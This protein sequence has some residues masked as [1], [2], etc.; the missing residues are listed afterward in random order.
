MRGC[1]YSSI[2]IGLI[3]AAGV[4]TPAPAA[5]SGTLVPL[6]GAASTLSSTEWVSVATDE[7][8]AGGTRLVFDLEGFRIVPVEI[9]GRR[10]VDVRIDGE[11]QLRER[12]APALPYVCR[13]IIIPDDARMDVRV[14]ASS[15]RE[16]SD[17][18][19]IPSKGP[20]LRTVDP[21]TIPYEFGAVYGEDRWYPEDL[22]ARREPY[23]LRDYRGL[24]VELHP[25]QYNPGQRRLRV[26]D[27][28]EVEVVPVGAAEHNLLTRS[29]TPEK[30]APV[31]AGLYAEHFLNFVPP[32]SN[33]QLAPGKMLIIAHDE[34]V[35]YMEPFVTWKNQ[36]GLPT[37]LV[38]LSHTGAGATDPDL[39]LAYIQSLYRIHNLA[40]VLLVG[41][42]AQVPSPYVPFG[43]SDPSYSLVEG[44]DY[45]PDL[46]VGRLSAETVEGVIL[47]V[48]KFVDYEQSPEVG[49]SWYHKGVGIGSGQG[50]E[51]GDDD[52]ADFIHIDYIR[53]D[54]LN[55]TYTQVDTIYAA[56]PYQATAQMVTDAV[57]AGRSIINYCGHGSSMRWT[58]TGFSNE[59]V[60]ALENHNQLPWVFS[61]ACKNG[62][63]ASGTC[64][65]EAWL[66]ASHNGMPTGAV[67]MYASSAD[68]AWAPPMAAQDETVDLLVAESE[69]VFGALC[70]RGSLLMMDE[71]DPGGRSEF[72]HWHIFGDPSMVV[73]C[74]TP[75]PLAVDHARRIDPEAESFTLSVPGVA[76]A[77]CALS[78]QGTTL[79]SALTDESGDARIEGLAPLPRHEAI[80]LTVTG[81]NHI[82]HVA[83][84][85]VEEK[86][87][88][89]VDLN[90]AGLSW[91]LEVGGSRTGELRI[92][93]AAQGVEPLSFR[94]RL[95]NIDSGESVS[96]LRA[97]PTAGTI[98]AGAVALIELDASAADL[99]AGSHEAEIVV[100]VG[101]S[102]SAA[103]LVALEVVG[104]QAAVDNGPGARGVPR[105]LTLQC[106]WPNPA[107]GSSSI[108]FALPARSDVNLAVFDLIGR[109]V[110]A[111]VSERRPAGDHRV[112][113]DGRDQRGRQ[114]PTGAYVLR[115]RAAGET[116]TARLLLVR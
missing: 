37:M 93:L 9:D 65:A 83:L 71:Y 82:P 5:D 92:V 39:L 94:I 62:R 30:M 25:V 90:P 6:D 79:G 103:A 54:L 50:D 59:Q 51:Y 45:Y 75:E 56:I 36:R 53:T 64:F 102:R 15:F 100:M 29:R 14:V 80:T 31:F 44:D 91:V 95:L 47:Q 85:D 88:P 27:R 114:V 28:V 67:G 34:F 78:F 57:N 43:Y 111:L 104:G 116:R 70:Y 33:D 73:R 4:S 22:L 113:W 18:D 11:P 60:G 32:N 46:I 69:T 110:R 96:W 26:Y 3:W 72:L 12:G 16:Y 77:L 40:Y 76:G 23:V 81:F 10:H 7:L 84:I 89:V 58:T 86:V 98:A 66:R 55:F 35:P 61:V 21:A 107:V 115:L 106:P 112:I 20:L 2:I 19:V 42:A 17:L 108:G 52:E 24:V 38:P 105:A 63:F 49:G 8:A 68:M 87:P 74:D 109:Q 41:D 97:T 1:Y 48:R 101:E 99:A 13:S